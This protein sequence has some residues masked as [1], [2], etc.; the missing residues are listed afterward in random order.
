MVGGLFL[1]RGLGTPPLLIRVGRVVG[2]GFCFLR[3]YRVL[4]AENKNRP[5]WRKRLGSGVRGQ[6]SGSEKEGP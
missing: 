2:W 1:D 6:G 5:T 4:V 3:V